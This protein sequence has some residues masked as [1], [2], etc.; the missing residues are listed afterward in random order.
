MGDDQ[1]G[2]C[3]TH[4]DGLPIGTDDDGEELEPQHAAKSVIFLCGHKTSSDIISRSPLPTPR[5]TPIE[6]AKLHLVEKD[7]RKPYLD[8]QVAKRRSPTDSQ[9]H[10][11]ASSAFAENRASTPIA[12]PPIT[13]TFNGMSMAALAAMTNPTMPQISPLLAQQQ[14]AAMVAQQA[15]ATMMQLSQSGFPHPGQQLSLTDPFWQNVQD[16]ILMKLMQNQLAMQQNVF[17][18][19]T[20]T[21]STSPVEEQALPFP[22]IPSAGGSTPNFSDTPSKARSK[23]K[24]KAVS[25]PSKRRKTSSSSFQE[26]STPTPV[27][28]MGPPS[29]KG[30][31]RDSSGQLAFFV[32]IAGHNR[33]NLVQSIKVSKF[34][35]SS[36][37]LTGFL[38]QWR[39]HCKQH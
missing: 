29:G 13:P 10:S 9:S 39:S 11:R 36:L 23:S 27:K 16:T 35:I 7:E 38:A 21:I 17:T 6:P 2:G 32:Q 12:P 26:S 4:D 31:F 14:A 24:Q 33:F 37:N 30:L 15:Q 19:P 34:C 1:Y 8:Q 22:S 20:A 25:P 3:L 5:Q 18:Q 28:K